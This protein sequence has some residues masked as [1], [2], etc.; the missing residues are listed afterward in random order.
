MKTLTLLA[1]SLALVFTSVSAGL[2]ADD[3]EK[4]TEST[5]VAP[6]PPAVTSEPVVEHEGLNC[7][8]CDTCPPVRYYRYH[9]SSWPD[10]KYDNPSGQLGLDERNRHHRDRESW[11]IFND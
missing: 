6:E 1:A 4:V 7:E 10:V 2:R 9:E 3:Q 8:P 11:P 5:E